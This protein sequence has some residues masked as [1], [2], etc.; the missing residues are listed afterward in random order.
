ML[1]FFWQVQL[2]KIL[3]ENCDGMPFDVFGTKEINYVAS[4]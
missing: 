1:A 3:K 2:N 4:V